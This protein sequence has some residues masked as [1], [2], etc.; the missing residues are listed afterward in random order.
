VQD[1]Q[2]LPGQCT[3]HN[4]I[5]NSV[6]EATDGNDDPS[7]D[8]DHT[9]DAVNTIIDE[10]DCTLDSMEINIFGEAN[11]S[12]GHPSQESDVTV[13]AENSNIDEPDI[14]YDRSKPI[15]TIAKLTELIVDNDFDHIDVSGKELSVQCIHASGKVYTVDKVTDVNSDRRYDPD[16]NTVSEQMM[17]MIILVKKMV[18]KLIGRIATLMNLIFMIVPKQMMEMLSR[19]IKLLMVMLNKMMYPKIL[20]KPYKTKL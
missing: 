12:N 19:Q 13:N 17:F 6:G 1:E 14:I 3:H 16:L 8:P 9:I 11:E 10:P 7:K 5:I 15:D 18:F 2:E 20:F 4:E